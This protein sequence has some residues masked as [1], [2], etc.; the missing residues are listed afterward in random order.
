VDGTFEEYVSARGEVLL[1][2]AFLLCGDRYLAEDLVQ[3]VL[4]RV[5]D[6]WHRLT[7]VEHPDAYLRTAIVRQFL[8]WR[9]R[10]ASRETSLELIAEP[11]GA[12][13]DA[14]A[15]HAAR[16]EMWRLLAE[17]PR[18]QRAVLVLRFYE[19]LTDEHIAETLGCRPA[20]VRVH[21]SRG[22]A[23]LRVALGPRPIDLTC[24][25]EPVGGQS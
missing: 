23:R 24:Q 17:L 8:S 1:R 5:H 20:T 13:P 7:H 3:E 22:L 25:T 16:D 15:R 14:T 19:D 12:S 10:R 4:A 11:A 18:K 21:A 6:R 9:R 2:F